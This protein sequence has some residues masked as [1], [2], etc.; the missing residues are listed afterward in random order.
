VRRIVVENGRD[1]LALDTATPP[2]GFTDNL[3]Q[4]SH[5]SWLQWAFEPLEGRGPE[6][7]TLPLFTERLYRPE[8]EVF[9]RAGC[10]SA[11][12][13]RCRSRPARARL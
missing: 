10:V 7:E 6:V 2:D 8:E 5:E 12:P 9:I 4:P 13:A 3:W 11:P 1:V